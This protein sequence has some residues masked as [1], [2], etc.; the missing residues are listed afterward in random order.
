MSD[1]LDNAAIAALLM[2]SKQREEHMGALYRNGDGIGRTP[3]V[4]TDSGDNVKGKLSVPIGSLAGLFHNHPFRRLERTDL[5]V[6]RFSEEDKLQATKLG[7]PSYII[8]PTGTVLRFD[9]K[10]NSTEEVLGEYPIEELKKMIALHITQSNYPPELKQRLLQ[11]LFLPPE[12][13][14]ATESP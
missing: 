11:S 10:T 3:T 9:P 13:V 14:S 6:R 8:T 5:D 7:V 2:L 1:E 4:T 12:K